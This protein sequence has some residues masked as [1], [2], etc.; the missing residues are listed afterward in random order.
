[1]TVARMRRGLTKSALAEAVGVTMRSISAYEKGEMEPSEETLAQIANVL[2]FHVSFFERD[3]IERP[4]VTTAS[5][6]SLASMT[7]GRRNAAIAA[8]A[9]A[10]E[11]NDWI[12]KQFELPLADIPSFR[13]ITPEAAAETVRGHWQLGEKP[14]RNVVHLLEQHGVRVFSLAEECR[15]VDAFSLWR[16]SKPFVF[17]NTYKSAERS[18][19]DAAHELGHLALHR[20]GGPAARGREAEREA[21]E[22]ASAFL[23]PRA[24]V[25]AVAPRYPTLSMIVSLKKQWNVSGAA[26]VHRLRGVGLLTEW[27]YRTLMVDLSQRG[28]RT[29]EPEPGER[30]TS[31]V[32][33]KVFTALRARGVTRAALARDLG[34][35]P[36]DIDALVFGLA[37]VA[38]RPSRQPERSVTS[39]ANV[40]R[41]TRRK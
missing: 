13:G 29:N 37:F 5:F 40:Y 17:L 26:L 41:L 23:M 22:F 14:I 28:Y 25:L 15:D 27:H 12:E 39:P 6:R 32:L 16:D 1:M 19:F 3:A 34:V 9:I 38:L 31:Q 36:A 10:V 35:E 11:L 30:E 20:H 7:A 24:S 2:G 33:Q 8:G 4:P 21:D 18:R